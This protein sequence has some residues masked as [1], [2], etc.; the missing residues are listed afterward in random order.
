VTSGQMPDV[1]L[2]AEIFAMFLGRLEFIVVIVSMIKL[3]RDCRLMIPRSLKG[4]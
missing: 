2:W 1:A 4:N 3:G